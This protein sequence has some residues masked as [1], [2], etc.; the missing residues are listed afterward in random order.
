MAFMTSLHDGHDI[1][2]STEVVVIGGGPAGSTAATILAQYGHRVC[3]FER[4]RF[5][6][7]HI[8]ESLMPETYWTLHRLG[9]LDQMKA[10]AFPK[11][12][13]VQ[14]VSDTGKES[15][16]FYFF[17]INPHESSQTWQV[18]RADFDRM[19]LDNA[20]RQGVRV[21]QGTR[22]LDVLLDGDRARGVRI[23]IAQ[24]QTREVT[25]QVV[26]DASGQSTLLGNKLK[27]RVPDPKLRKGAVWTYYRGARRDPGL[28]EGATLVLHVREKK[29]WFWYIP[30]PNDT[31][32]VGVVGSMD[33]LLDRPGDHEQIFYEEVERCPTVK[34]RLA[35]GQ[36]VS[37]FFATRDF[38]YR[39][40]R[41]AGYGWV[42]VGDAF[43][44]LDPIYS[45]GVF[46]ALKSGELAA[47]AI[48]EGLTLGDVGPERLGRW[49]PRFLR[50]M[51]S[52]RKLVYAFYEGFSFGQFVH[53]HPEYRRHLVDL[54]V[55]DLFKE[56]VT[57]IFPVMERYVPL[58][59]THSWASAECGKA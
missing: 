55:G 20:A 57:D 47:D 15:Q 53:T 41:A 43:G 26:V 6:R 48:H 39:C 44:F 37:G 52:M 54:L 50:G 28:D 14:F 10:S 1:P 13:S 11:K 12:Y 56:G 5:P 2:G 58:P 45:S 33:Y 32:S 9:V 3:L 8:G 21:Y 51:E 19:L 40:A 29:A 49:A 23:Q 22:V 34:A 27:L 17:E 46:L 59:Q 42:L 38:S 24:G 25:C 31:V 16:P 7:F 35:C 30:L 18:W 4:E 36:R